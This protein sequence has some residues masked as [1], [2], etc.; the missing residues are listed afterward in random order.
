MRHVAAQF[1]LIKAWRAAEPFSHKCWLSRQ[2]FFSLSW[3]SGGINRRLTIRYDVISLVFIFKLRC[4]T[5]QLATSIFSRNTVSCFHD[6]LHESTFC[7]T[8]LDFLMETYMLHGTTFNATSI[9]NIILVPKKLG[10]GK[11]EAE[12]FLIL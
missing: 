1:L 7:A 9:H 8:L 4:Y 2:V 6:M 3:H 11:F 5:G 10:T 12:S